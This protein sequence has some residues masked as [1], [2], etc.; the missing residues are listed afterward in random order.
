[1][2]GYMSIRNQKSSNQWA[3]TGAALLLVLIIVPGY[4]TLSAQTVAR[5]TLPLYTA[6][7]PAAGVEIPVQLETAGQSISGVLFSIDYDQRCL[8]FNGADVNGDGLL[9]GVQPLT[10][11]YFSFSAAFSPADTQGE[12]DIVILD[13]SLPFAELVTGPLAI[14]HFR[15]TCT[16]VVGGVESVSIRF[17]DHPQ[18]SFGDPL[19]RNLAGVWSGG[20]ID[21][22]DA[23]APPATLTPTPT[24]QASATATPFVA[25]TN[26]PMTPTPSPTLPAENVTPTATS[27]PLLPPVPPT[28]TP[29]RTPASTPTATPTATLSPIPTATSSPIPTATSRSP[30]EAT[31]GGQSADELFLPI[32]QQS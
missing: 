31:P 27:A 22:L 1:M 9:D 2:A 11:P 5:L 14:L 8:E 3:V 17:S 13:L 23:A 20:I 21:I 6:T 16:P 30:L 32:I 19:G 26:T 18:P 15:T 24:L 28:P 4:R 29:T 7:A 25:A 10:P 12:I